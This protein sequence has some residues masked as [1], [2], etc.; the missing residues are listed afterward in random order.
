MNTAYTRA[1]AAGVALLALASAPR[2]AAQKPAAGRVVLLD[3]IIAV[4]NDEVITRRDLDDRIKVVLSQL[5]QQGTPLPPSDVLEK[6]V[7]ERVIYNQVQLQYAKET[8]LR[9]EDAIL[10]KAVNRIAEDNKITVAA[11]RQALEKDGVN[12][13]KFREEL[14]DEIIIVRLRER[15]VDNKVQIADSEIDNFLSTLQTHDGKVEEFNL[16]H[17]LVRVPEQA[18]PEQLQERRARAEQALAQIK[19]G[20]DFRQVAASF[21]DAP[22]AVQGGAMGWRELAQLPTI[23]AE[24]VKNLKSG[25]VGAVLRSPNGFHIVRVN[26]RRGQDAPMIVSQT[27]ARH[28]LIKTT[29][30]VSENDAKDRLVKLKERLDNNA[31]FAELARL[32]SEDGSASRGGDLGWLSPGDTVP[33]F[34]KA[35]DGLKPGQISEPT[36]S[37]FG[38]HLIQ[39]LERRNQDMSQQQQRLRARQALRSQ[40]ADEAYQEWV[41]QLRDKAFVEYRLEDR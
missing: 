1:L 31:D 2:A 35:M 11:M 40:K 28:I 5:K 30:L 4:V 23:F 39:V 41:R 27:H 17:I 24:A 25:E 29:E 16:S 19:G 3:R 34:E 6:Q 37:P 38:W 33:E 14:R 20:A 10:E 12:F 18:S 8:G 36:R 21:S 9:V 26:E 32:Q 7:L 15:E 13:N 22:D